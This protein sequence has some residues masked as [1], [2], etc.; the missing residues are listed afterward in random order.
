MVC[1]P[2]EFSDRRHCD[3]GDISIIIC[4]VTSHDHMFKVLLVGF[5][6]GS[7]PW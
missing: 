3:S 7:P 5:I 1:H 2:G 6:G 4:L